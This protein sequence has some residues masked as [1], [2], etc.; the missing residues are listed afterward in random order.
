V[1]FVGQLRPEQ[2][3]AVRTMAESDNGVL[4]ATTA[5]GKTV[6]AAALIAEIKVN[7]L[8]IV[9]TKALLNQWKERLEEFLAINHCEEE[10]TTHRG[11]KRA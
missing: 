1:E 5:F 3:E 4:S 2:S 10:N 8:V 6:T 9:H 7:T 11:R